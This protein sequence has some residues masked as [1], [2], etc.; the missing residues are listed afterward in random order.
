MEG[1]VEDKNSENSIQDVEMEG[2]TLTLNA[3]VENLRSFF[4]LKE[5]LQV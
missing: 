4:K 2:I 3:S 5:D 1:L